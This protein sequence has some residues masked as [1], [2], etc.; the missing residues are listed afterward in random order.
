M[1]NTTAHVNSSV[2]CL[3]M[4]QTAKPQADNERTFKKKKNATH[5]LNINIA[6]LVGHFCQI[7]LRIL[8]VRCV[9]MLQAFAC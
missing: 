3:F 9:N 8:P 4:K 1:L 7:C 2:L 5:G 6:L